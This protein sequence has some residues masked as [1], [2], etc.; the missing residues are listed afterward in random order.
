MHARDSTVILST[1]AWTSPFQLLRCGVGH[2]ALDLLAQ[3][4][5][6]VFVWQWRFPD[7]FGF[8][9]PT[10]PVRSRIP[11]CICGGQRLEEIRVRLRLCTLVRP[12]GS[13]LGSRA[14]RARNSADIELSI[15]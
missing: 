8:Q 9:A 7:S 14:C 12:V 1:M 3:L 2:R 13:Q 6:R 4:S 5:N 15:Y 10:A 11:R